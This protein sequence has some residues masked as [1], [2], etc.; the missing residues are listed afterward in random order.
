MS[1]QDLN[2]LANSLLRQNSF[3]ADGSKLKATSKS[4]ILFESKT[5]LI[6]PKEVSSPK[7]FG[8]DCDVDPE[9]LSYLK[10]VENKK[11]GKLNLKT[12]QLFLL[13]RIDAAA[14][15][16]ILTSEAEEDGYLLL[17]AAFADHLMANQEL[18]PEDWKLSFAYIVFIGSSFIFDYDGKIRH[19][20]IFRD[21]GKWIYDYIVLSNPDISKRIMF[22]AFKK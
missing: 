12:D 20:V 19:R 1:T 16:L 9:F 10:I 11:L 3:G 22:A 14:N 18:I 17:N 8:V 21:Y 5:V 15:T 6:T 13:D 7:I 4:Q 2:K